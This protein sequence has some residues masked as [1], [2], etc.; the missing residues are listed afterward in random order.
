GSHRMSRFVEW[1]KLRRQQCVKNRK[2]PINWR[3]V[4]MLRSGEDRCLAGS[5][6]GYDLRVGR[7]P[8]GSYANVNQPVIANDTISITQ[9]L[10]SPYPEIERNDT[11]K[12]DG[13]VAKHIDSDAIPIKSQLSHDNSAPI[14]PSLGPPEATSTPMASIVPVTVGPIGI[15]GAPAN[16][17]P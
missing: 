3:C 16:A 12:A 1:L 10:P 11:P 2:G 7:G 5:M 14:S 8:E 9:V 4:L 13:S 6:L 15:S 17:A